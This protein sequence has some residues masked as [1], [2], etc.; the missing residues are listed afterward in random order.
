MKIKFLNYMICFLFLST[1]ILAGKENLKMRL[2]GKDKAFIVIKIEEDK[3]TPLKKN[4]NIKEN[5]HIVK[6]GDT[7]FSISK[8]YNI[9][10]KTLQ[11]INK[12]KNR[13]LIIVGK[14]LYLEE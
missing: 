11:K 13:N 3:S 7:L 8:K 12:I 4:N 6:K 2:I 5:Y 1:I 14:K 9:K 10:M